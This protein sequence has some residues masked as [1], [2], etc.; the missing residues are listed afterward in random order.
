MEQS[1]SISALTQIPTCER[2][3]KVERSAPVTKCLG[4][5]GRIT[6]FPLPHPQPTSC[7][8][9][10]GSV[11]ATE[12]NERITGLQ[13]VAVSGVVLAGQCRSWECGAPWQT[14]DQPSRPLSGKIISR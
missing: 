11:L 5:G 6:F 10:V 14:R 9:S 12:A 8:Y 4:S 2:G 7:R 13:V 1:V 3:V